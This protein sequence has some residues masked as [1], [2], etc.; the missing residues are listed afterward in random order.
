MFVCST[1]TEGAPSLR[2]LQGWAAMLLVPF[3]FLCNCVIKPLA[4]AFP[5][6]ALRKVREGRGT[7]FVDD[8]RRDQRPGHPPPT[9]R[10]NG[11]PHVSL[12]LRDMGV[13]AYT[14]VPAQLNQ[15]ATDSHPALG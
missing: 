2:F 10:N 12:V 14:I 15:R 3:D 13:G 7:H 5:N 8:R 6:P 11:V 1:P 4:Q 9:A